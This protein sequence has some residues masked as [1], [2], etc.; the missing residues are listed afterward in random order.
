[1]NIF[2][3]FVQVFMRLSL[4]FS[5]MLL[6]GYFFKI[7]FMQQLLL[8]VRIMFMTLLLVYFRTTTSLQK[9]ITDLSKIHINNPKFLVFLAALTKFLD[10]FINIF[11]NTNLNRKSLKTTIQSIYD[12][13]ANL[14]DNSSLN[15]DIQ[16]NT[17]SYKQNLLA[18]L[19][20]LFILV[21]SFLGVNI[22]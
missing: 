12:M 11:K 4:L 22:L 20:L 6:G 5:A 18:D 3:N 9:F 21:V 17:N 1:M 15:I 14:S 8:I 10:D 13:E 7:D 19:S 2:K 16:S